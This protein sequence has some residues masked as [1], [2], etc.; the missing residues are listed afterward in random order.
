MKLS[1]NH[2]TGWIRG[3]KHIHSPHFNNRPQDTSISLL[4]I[5]CISLPPGLYGN[6]DIEQFFIGNLDHDKH[7]YY[8]T[9]T[10]L[11]VCP[12]FLIKRCGKLIQ[13]VATHDRAWHA[14]VSSYQNLDNCNDYSLGI[15]LEGTDS[16]SF[17]KKQ[18]KTLVR[19]TDCLKGAYPDTLAERIVGHSDIAPGRKTDPG[20]GF[21]WSFYI[22]Q[23]T[24][25]AI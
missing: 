6:G 23:L 24:K 3:A 15:E 5:H 10:E 8:Q 13:F 25:D 12:H 7:P 9:I 18:Y 19:L 2:E 14:G 11:K 16:S 21:N 20:T 17:D 4:V 22:N 1:I